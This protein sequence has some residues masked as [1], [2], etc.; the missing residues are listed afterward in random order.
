MPTVQTLAPEQ[1][2]ISGVF[3]LFIFGQFYPPFDISMSII[4]SIKK[5]KKNISSI[6]S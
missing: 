3:R 2:V 5:K 1:A 6:I 4:N